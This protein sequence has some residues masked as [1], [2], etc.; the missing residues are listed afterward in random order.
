MNYRDY[1]RIMTEYG[2]QESEAVVMLID[3]VKS[4]HACCQELKRN[5]PQVTGKVLKKHLDQI[6]QWEKKKDTLIRIALRTAWYEKKLD[7]RFLE[8]Q[9]AMIMACYEWQED[10]RLDEEAKETVSRILTFSLYL[11]HCKMHGVR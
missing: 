9:D 3:K 6:E 7:L 2:L 10:E 1:S 8:D 11:Q 5:A 4:L